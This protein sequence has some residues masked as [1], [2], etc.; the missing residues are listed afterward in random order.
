MVNYTCPK[1]NKDFKRKEN[2]NYHLNKKFNCIQ[3]QT[4][5]QNNPLIIKTIQNNPI[6]AEKTDDFEEKTENIEKNKKIFCNYCKKTFFNNANLN[7][8]IRNNSCKEKKAQDEE[9]ENIFKLLLEKEEQMKKIEEEKKKFEEDKKMLFSKIEE[10][11][12]KREEEN[13]KNIKNLEDY[14]KKITDLNFELN[15]KV[16]NLMEKLSVNNINHGVI[17]NTINNINNINNINITS[18][19]LVDFGKEDVKEIDFGLF[20]KIFGKV[21]KHIFTAGASNIWNNKPKYKNIYVSDLS[22]EKAMTVKNGKFELTPLNSVLITINQQLLQYFKYNLEHLDKIGDKKKLKEFDDNINKYYKM[23]F[24]AYTDAKDRFIPSDDR[25]DEFDR[26]VNKELKEYFYNIK[27]NVKDNYNQIVDDIKKDNILKKINYEP[28][29]KPRGRPKKILKDILED[30]SPKKVIL[31]TTTSTIPITDEEP[32]N[33]QP[34]KK[35]VKDKTNNEFKF[36]GY[37]PEQLQEV[38]EKFWKKQLKKKFK[39]SCVVKIE[40]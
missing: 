36:E 6:F 7:K 27:D 20:N 8:H 30:S 18:D 17:N 9:K 24:R 13:K 10:E 35:T 1:C 22:R 19:K 26:V 38:Q 16:T 14:I 37:T 33:A 40:D 12:K 11:N 25:L 34:V 32:I 39:K 5:I 4:L 21:G 2:L 3:N 31:N 23:Y 15:N 28:P 29:K